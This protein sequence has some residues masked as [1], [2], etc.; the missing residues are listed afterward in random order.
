MALDVIVVDVTIIRAAI[1][2]S[3]EDHLPFWDGVIIETARASG[4]VLVL[5]EDLQHGRAFGT[6]RMENPFLD[7]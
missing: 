4:C 6:T 7:A 2:P 1:A 5:S 3:R